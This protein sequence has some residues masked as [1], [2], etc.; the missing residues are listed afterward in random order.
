MVLEGCKILIRES[1]VH[2]KVPYLE[3]CMRSK[4]CTIRKIPT[5]IYI[6]SSLVCILKGGKSISLVWHYCTSTFI[7]DLSSFD[8]TWYSYRY[9][10]CYLTWHDPY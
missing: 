5:A 1:G 2:K 10:I 7:K 3:I 9:A 6:P 8:L 4:Y